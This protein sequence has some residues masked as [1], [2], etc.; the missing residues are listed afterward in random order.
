[1][2]QK[3]IKKRHMDVQ[4][5]ILAMLITCGL[6]CAI[7]LVSMPTLQAESETR[8]APLKMFV[9]AQK[10]V[11]FDAALRVN[12]S[13]RGIIHLVHAGGDKWSMTALRS[14]LV[15]IEIKR[16][17]GK[18]E[19]WYVDVEPR[20]EPTKHKDPIPKGQE[21]G[22]TSCSD[23]TS[24][25]TGDALINHLRDVSKNQVTI[26]QGQSGAIIAI[27]LPCATHTIEQW[28]DLLGSE[29][30][31]PIASGQ[32]PLLCSEEDHTVMY[33]VAS[34]VEL[35]EKQQSHHRGR[36]F[37]V[38]LAGNFTP[39]SFAPNV[40]ASWQNEEDEGKKKILA[41]PLLMIPAGTDATVKSGGETLYEIPESD[42]KVRSAWHEHGI[43][44]TM[45]LFPISTDIIRADYQFVLKNP[46]SGERNYGVNQ[47]SARADL[48][49]AKKVLV[50]TVDLSSDQTDEKKDALLSQVPIIGP[51]FRRSLEQS[52]LAQVLL[53][54]EVSVITAASPLKTSEVPR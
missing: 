30:C 14:G 8:S 37:H 16:Q 38:E 51:L 48:P 10:T 46:G 2:A 12:V 31:G 40:S 23:D 45:K 20:P 49:F 5:E 19:V 39:I 9:G 13:R 11:T 54:L 17:G 33:R 44:L 1:M 3:P 22:P 18:T 42:G 4:R 25:L 47:I 6:A 24:F 53:W 15:A 26:M 43:A 21:A 52:S 28:R 35:V 32:I 50:G 36:D 34:Q 29:S 41:E 7:F 27:Q